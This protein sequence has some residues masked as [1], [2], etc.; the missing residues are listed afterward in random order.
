MSEINWQQIRAAYEAGGLSLRALAAQYGV[1][2]TYLIERRDKEHWNR[3]DRPPLQHRPPTT[4]QT[5]SHQPTNPP[6]DMNL[7]PKKERPTHEKQAAFLAA[8]A[9]SAIILTSAQEAGISRQTV[10]DWLE[11]DQAFSLAYHR[12]KEDARDI[13]RAEILRRGKD[14]WDEPVY[15]LAQYAGTV[16]KYSDTLLIFHAK[17]LMPEYREKQQIEHSGTVKLER[18][19]L[20]RFSDEELAVLEQ[21]AA[22]AVRHGGS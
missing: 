22:K 5:P 3:P 14:G 21:L 13:I 9:K 12:A 6:T 1:S 2:K 18:P 16:R 20:S 7:T 17:M 4:K 15:Q 10:Y 11:H 19:D 8:Y